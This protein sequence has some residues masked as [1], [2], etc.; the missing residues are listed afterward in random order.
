M[1]RTALVTG[2]AGFIGSALIR[3]LASAGYRVHGLDRAA[4]DDALR[5]RVSH[6][7]VGDLSQD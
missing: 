2:A 7:S 6:W 1:T 5:A 4:P 3:A